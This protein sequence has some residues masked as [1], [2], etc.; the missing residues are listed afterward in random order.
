MLFLCAYHRNAATQLARL[1]FCSRM[2][3]SVQ[4]SGAKSKVLGGL[5]KNFFRHI[6][7]PLNTLPDSFHSKLMGEVLCRI[8]RGWDQ[9]SYLTLLLNCAAVSSIMHAYTEFTVGFITLINQQY[10]APFIYNQR[11]IYAN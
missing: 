7:I 11:G 1:H 9:S 3:E 8:F 5:K 6:Y 4:N 2:S 10:T